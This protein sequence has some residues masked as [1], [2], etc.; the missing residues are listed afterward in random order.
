MEIRPVFGFQILEVFNR[1]INPYDM[2]HVRLQNQLG[3]DWYI[4]R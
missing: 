4:W 2:F 1:D 3:R